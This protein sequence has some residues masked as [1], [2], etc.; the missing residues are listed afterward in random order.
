ML[1]RT[2]RT[3]L[4][5]ALIAA[6]AITF[7]LCCNWQPTKTNAADN[8]PQQPAEGMFASVFGIGGCHVRNR[9]AADNAT[10]VPQMAAIGLRVFR[11]PQAAWGELEP[12]E[13]KWN[14]EEFDKQLAYLEEQRFEYGVLLH[15]NGR[16]NKLDKP[17]TLPVNNLPAWSN[18]VTQV[19]RHLKA[20][21]SKARHLEIWNEPPNGTGRDQSP[22]DYAKI[23][24]AA[25]EAAKAVDPSF[26]IGLSAKSAHVNYL[27][28]VIKGG[29]KDHFD[30]IVLHPY[31]VLNGV[32]NNSGADAVYM[33]V[34]PTARKMLAAQN[35][36]RVNVPIIFTEL[37]SD[38]SKGADH[39][40]RALVKAYT[41]G[42]A[43]GVSCIQWFEGRDGD[44]GPMGLIDAKGT[45]RPSYTAMQQMIHHFGHRPQYL[46]WVLLKDQH[47]G[48]AFQGAD[49]TILCTWSRP[50]KPRVVE[51]GAEVKIANPITGNVFAARSIELTTS[52]LLVLDVPESLLAKA[53]ANKDKP[54]DWG[55]DYSNAKSVSIEFGETTI[56]K[57]LHTLAGADVAAAVVAYGGS[58]RAGNVPGGNMFTVDPNF[59]SYTT[60][61][62]EITAVV[63]RNPAGDNAGFKLVYESTTGFKTA[64]PGWYTVPDNKKWH[65]ITWKIDDPQFVNYWGFNF[66]LE[67]DG[68]QFNKYLI[69]SM[70]VTK[71]P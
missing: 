50:G 25:H 61:P 56:E 53:K 34:V 46:G 71:Q 58:A 9:H 52:P 26:Q 28:Q 42:I 6:A 32:A 63:R 38:A 54:F 51:F 14:W 48:F 37:G 1:L 41:M 33:H 43:Q 2:R 31:E 16:W 13:G 30:Y 60:V 35:P 68:N 24:V 19:A 59:L 20:K 23:V 3:Y 49:S 39:Q 62:L 44:S 57:G 15:G 18:Y 36:S 11:S 45:P 22:A 64:A 69:Q 29:A 21:G 66:N 70:T 5:P 7:A 65:T 40:A 55:G 10:W 8:A 12:E 67:S 47:Y 27:E 17:G 4:I